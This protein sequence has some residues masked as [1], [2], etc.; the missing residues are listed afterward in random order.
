[1]SVDAHPSCYS[2][3]CMVHFRVVDVHSFPDTFPDTA[4]MLNR[5]EFCTTLGVGGVG[6]L[7][8]FSSTATAQNATA[9]TV[10]AA[11]VTV[12]WDQVQAKPKP[13]NTWKS[14]PTR[15]VAKLPGFSPQEK[16]R[17]ESRFGGRLD[18]KRDATGFFRVEKIGNR[19]WL[20]DPEGHLFIHK[21]V[22]SV[23]IRSLGTEA[24]KV[25]D[26]RYGSPE[27]WVEETFL[28][29]RRNGFNG[30]GCWGDVELARFANSKTE[31]PLAYTTI[32]NFMSSYGRLRGGTYQRPGNTG[33]PGDCIFAFDPEFE[34]FCDSHAKSLAEFKDDP[35]LLG[36]FSDNEMPNSL[37]MLENYLSIENKADPGRKAAERWMA[38]R[39]LKVDS[40]TDID[41]EEFMA[42]VAHRYITT[43]GRAVRKYDPNHLFLGSRIHGRGKRLPTY[44]TAM[45]EGVDVM[46]VNL[47]DVWTPTESYTQNW[48]KWTGKPFMITEFYTKGE[49]SGM[50]NTSGA[51]WIVPTQADRG[52]SYQNT[53]L[54]LLESKNA[55]GWHY[56]KYMDNDPTATGVDPSNTDS[57]KGIVNNRFVPYDTFLAAQRELNSQ[58]YELVD[59]FET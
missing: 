48:T 43:V 42:V 16:P 32:W 12:E 41:R 15:T 18:Q 37:A 49:D 53:V 31:K 25:L 30:V 58:V 56:F 51:G 26:T 7:A 36:H 19:F 44:F 23:N 29:L 20:I 45:S 21:A 2:A 38:E 5:R 54:A 27:R 39:N 34:T 57:N 55:V 8:P 59:Y 50:G 3:C 9:A 13:P 47:Y 4:I 52:K 35:N 24:K 46:S 6:V 40:L 11:D 1:M 28:L 14:Y 10:A 22:S 17:P 33:Y